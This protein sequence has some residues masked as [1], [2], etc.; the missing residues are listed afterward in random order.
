MSDNLSN[1]F[2]LSEMKEPLPEK[3]EENLGL[4]NDADEARSNLKMLIDTGNRALEEMLNLAIDSE[5][6]RAYE[7]LSTMINS[8]AELNSKVLDMYNKQVDVK[9]KAATTTKTKETSDTQQVVNGNVTNQ[10]I[11]FTGTTAELS[12]FLHD[13]KD[14]PT[15]NDKVIENAEIKSNK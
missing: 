5:N 4:D 8:L 9:R 10:S 7:V 13:L 2:G 14:Q 15:F 11:V 6:P 3:R 1:L 12:K